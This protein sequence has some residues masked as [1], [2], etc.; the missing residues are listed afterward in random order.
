LRGQPGT[1]YILQ[2]SP[3][4]ASWTP[5]ATNTLTTTSATINIPNITDSLSQFYRALWQP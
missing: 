4:L 5:F 1:P 3:D 2:S